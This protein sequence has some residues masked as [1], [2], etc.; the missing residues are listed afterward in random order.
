M[1]K[2]E[3]RLLKLLDSRKH[4]W[5]FDTEKIPEQSLVNECLTKA[6]KVTPSKNNFMPYHVN[7]IGPGP[8]NQ[9]LK[10]KIHGLSRLN[11][12]RT[13]VRHNVNNIENYD[14]E[15]NNPNFLFY[16]TAPYILVFSQRV[17][18]PNPYIANAIIEQNDIYEQMH[19]SMFGNFQTTAAVEIGMFMQ[20]AT[21]FLLEQGIDTTY[22]KCYPAELDAWKD[23]PFVEG[24]VMLLAGLGYCKTSRRDGMSEADKKIDYKPEPEEII[25]FR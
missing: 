16:N 11:K 1:S 8:E 12:R 5:G 23:F 13:N 3:K 17:A 24:P 18:E 20:N 15:G 2:M 19:A 10:D 21:A 7:V 25:R 22:I 14:E 6:W 9:I 4:V